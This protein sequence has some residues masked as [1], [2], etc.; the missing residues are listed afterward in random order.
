M[1][2]KFTYWTDNKDVYIDINE[3]IY[4]SEIGKDMMLGIRGKK[5]DIQ[6]KKS[7]N[8]MLEIMKGKI[9]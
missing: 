5:E 9:I 6:L 1:M 4:M 3:I 2:T 7:L 8:E